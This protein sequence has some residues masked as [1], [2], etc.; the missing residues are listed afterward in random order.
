M[1]AELHESA[2]TVDLSSL[3]TFVAAME[4]GHPIRA[5]IGTLPTVMPIGDYLGILPSLWAL[6]ERP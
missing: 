1:A 2:T 6:S 5:V 3:K 4:H